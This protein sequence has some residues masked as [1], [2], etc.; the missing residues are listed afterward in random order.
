MTTVN[1][2]SISGRTVQVAYLGAY[3]G[4]VYASATMVSP[5][6]DDPASVAYQT[7]HPVVA[8]DIFE[9]DDVN[10]LGNLIVDSSGLVS[11]DSEGSFQGR[12]FDDGDQ[13]YGDWESYTFEVVATLA[14][15]GTWTIGTITKGQ[16]TASL[17]PVY[18]GTDADSYEYTLNGSAWIAFT[19][20]INL[21]AL[22]PEA[23]QYGAV[24]AANSVGAGTPE[25]FSFMTERVP[26]PPVLNTPL[27]DL[28]LGEQ[29]AVNIDLD[30]Y[31]SLAASYV[32]AGLPAGSGLSLSGSTITGTTNTNDTDAS[33]LTITVTATNS[34]GSI[35]DAFSVSVV[36]DTPP[37]L[38][39][40]PLTTLNTAPVVSG[41]SGDAISLVLVVNGVTYNPVPSGGSWLQ[42][43]NELPL[44][45]YVM[46]LNGQDASGNQAIERKALL[47]VVDEIVASA[48]GLFQP[49]FRPLSRSVNNPMFR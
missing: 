29:Q 32:V 41:S 40:S 10:G 11:A 5:I 49:L 44:N 24:R 42:Q 17:T 43:L 1:V 38:S 34:D 45:T 8:G 26:A 3:T 13:A 48:G 39:I 25:S 6:T 23:S 20:T 22:E 15:Q 36:D 19:G 46:S 28:N 4:T 27:P 14:P 18:S 33:P 12:W 9:W 16:T 47:K 37:V 7:T 35:Q 31:F 21:S 2:S 30:N